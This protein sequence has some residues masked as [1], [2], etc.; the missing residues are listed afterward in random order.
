MGVTD[1]DLY[2]RASATL[3]A[4][5]AEYAR[6]SPGASVLRIHGATAAVFPNDPERGV[7]NNT[8]V[9]R[10]L[11]PGRREAT[12]EATEDAY[13]SAGVDR[14][15]VWVHE[16]DEGMRSELISRGYSL[17]E[18]TRAMS[19]SLDELISPTADVELERID[20]ADYIAYLAGIGVPD[21]LLS[22][23]D[24]EAFHRLAVRP[25]GETVATGLAFDHDGDCGVFN[26]S[27][28]ETRR[29]RGLG[30]AITAELLREA[31]GRGCRTASL[32]STAMAER[33]YASVGFRDLGR[34][35]EF[36]P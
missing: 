21:G 2:A 24:P 20:W 4:S 31:I 22:G 13:R 8:L 16:S 36:V 15:A 32:Q 28:I 26:V 18:I 35:F 10:G 6:G 23:A 1:E 7:Y 29:R 3:L 5:W 12:I 9:D 34:I 25:A 33:V 14:F 19:M 11:A 30:T 17:D 27:T